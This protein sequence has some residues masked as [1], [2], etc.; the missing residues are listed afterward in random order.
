[1]DGVKILKAYRLIS[2][3]YDDIIENLTKKIEEYQ[4]EKIQFIVK[5]HHDSVCKKLMETE[6]EREAFEKI[7]GDLRKQISL[8]QQEI[9][10]LKK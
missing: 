6:A 9:I 3:A 10:I 1:M 8:L 4:K 2:S 5:E 7:I